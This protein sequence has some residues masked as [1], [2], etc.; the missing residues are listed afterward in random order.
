MVIANYNYYCH[1]HTW[2][3]IEGVVQEMVSL[4]VLVGLVLYLNFVVSALE[5]EDSL[6]DI[7]NNN[8]ECFNRNDSCKEC[9]DGKDDCYWCEPSKQCLDWKWSKSHVVP[10][11]LHCKGH[12]F[13]FKQCR[14]NGAGIIALI[15]VGTVVVVGLFLCCCVCCCCVCISRRRKRKYEK[16]QE[17]HETRK[18][19]IQSRNNQ[20][21]AERAA[22]RDEIRRKYHI[23]TSDHDQLA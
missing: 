19:A 16:L 2:G 22:R 11:D 21:R 20:N 13:Y 10:S 6:S 9:T 18:E 23:G 15:T 5:T 14:L 12:N 4:T 7:S 17:K 3:V 1:A 8:T